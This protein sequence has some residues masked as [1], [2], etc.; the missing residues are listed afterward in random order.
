[1][2][3]RV[4]RC[5][6]PFKTHSRHF[7]RSYV[8]KLSR[9]IKKSAIN[10]VCHCDSKQEVK[11]AVSPNCRAPH[12]RVAASPGAASPCRR[13]AG[14][15]IAASPRRDDA[16]RTRR[17]VVA[18]RTAAASYCHPLLYNAIFFL[19]GHLPLNTA[20]IR[21]SAPFVLKREGR[22]FPLSVY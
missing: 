6:P 8:R 17:R 2:Q 10:F 9:D 21:K 20:G 15:R 14:R 7:P 4:Q 3:S 22:Y 1:M 12:R 19:L 11:V 13:I 16:T 18:V 5:F